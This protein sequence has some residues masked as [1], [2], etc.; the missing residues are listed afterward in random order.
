[1][2]SEPRGAVELREEL[3]LADV[4]HHRAL[5]HRL[6]R[7]PGAGEA[8]VAVIFPEHLLRL[9]VRPEDLPEDVVRPDRLPLE[10]FPF[11]AAVAGAAFVAAAAA[12]GGEGAIASFSSDTM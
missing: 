4:V 2:C 1:L 3:L 5:F 9:G 10:S 6:R 12:F 11:F 7:L 8:A